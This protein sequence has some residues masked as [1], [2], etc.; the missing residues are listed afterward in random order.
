M[1]RAKSIPA[2]SKKKTQRY[3]HKEYSITLKVMKYFRDNFSG[4]KFV[5]N[6]KGYYEPIKTDTK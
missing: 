3:T 4:K 1:K 5:S 2:K 6:K